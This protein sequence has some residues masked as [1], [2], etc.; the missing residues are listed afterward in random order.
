[1]F[2]FCFKMFLSCFQLKIEKFTC[3]LLENSKTLTSLIPQLSMNPSSTPKPGSAEDPPPLPGGG[4]LDKTT[5]VEL[6]SPHLNDLTPLA[7]LVAGYA[8]KPFYE[9]ELSRVILHHLAGVLDLSQL[10]MEYAPPDPTRQDLDDNRVSFDG[11][12]IYTDLTRATLQYADLNNVDLRDLCG[13]YAN[14]SNAQLCGANMDD[15]QLYMAD[16]SGADLSNVNLSNANLRGANLRGANL[17]NVNLSDAVLDNADLTDANLTDANLS[18]AVL[19]DANLSY[20]TMVNVK[21]HSTNLDSANLS[22]VD[23]SNATMTNTYLNGAKLFGAN[24]E[25]AT[26]SSNV[27]LDG[28]DLTNAR[29][30]GV[31]LTHVDISGATTTNAD[32]TAEIE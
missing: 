2:T 30:V 19:N 9:D 6:V 28:A 25:N 13:S 4:I 17:F 20:A 18:D 15:I 29:L 32:F 5:V 31:D 1:M 27:R 11:C 7:Q 8:V 3:Y 23:L 16:L 22:M 10:V 12:D 26:L 14:L 21:L 24:L